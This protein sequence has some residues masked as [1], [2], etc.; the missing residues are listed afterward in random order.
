M[1]QSVFYG[2]GAFVGQMTGSTQCKFWSDDPTTFNWD[3]TKAI[4]VD[5]AKSPQ[6]HRVG[7]IKLDEIQVDDH[8]SLPVTPGLTQIG[9]MWPDGTTVGAVWLESRYYDNLDPAIKPPRVTGGDCRDY[10]LT[11]FIEWAGPLSLRRFYGVHAKITNQLGLLSLVQIWQPGRS[12][13]P[14]ESPL[15]TAWLDLAAITTKLTGVS[16][17]ANVNDEG[18]LFI[19]RPTATMLAL[20]GPKLPRGIGFDFI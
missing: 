20:A 7:T 13:V 17:I 9:P 8:T 10:E 15:A 6:A 2:F 12:L 11:S 5:L 1:T 14:N 19:D 18:P 4:P 3:I 16:S